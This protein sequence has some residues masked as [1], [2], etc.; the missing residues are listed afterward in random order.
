M[1][2]FLETYSYPPFLSCLKLLFQSEAKC[3]AIDFKMI[4]YSHA[5]RTHF[6]NKGFTFSLVLNVSFW[7]L[8]VAYSKI[9]TR[10]ASI[11]V[12]ILL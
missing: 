10:N 11:S 12:V 2:S 1:G 4:F 8:D 7:N 5:N 9:C 3:E 6:H